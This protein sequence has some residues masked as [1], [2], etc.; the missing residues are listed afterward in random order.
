MPDL[1]IPDLA[2][3]IPHYNDVRRLHRCL[4]A[5][6]PQLTP[7]TELVVAD[8]AST[9]DL[10]PIRTA[11]PDLRIVTQPEQGA[12]AARNK[13]VTETTAP[14]LAFL[15]ADC[16]PAADWL[17]TAHRIAASQGDAVTGGRVDVFDETPAPR[18]GAEGF[19]TVFAFDQA[20]YIADK[21][22]SVT[23]NLVTTRTVFDAIGPLVPG[24]SEDLEW[25]RRA[26][27]AGFAL[28]YA[29]DLA[30]SHPTRTDW[31]ALSRKWRRLTDESWGFE[32]RNGH[33]GVGVRAAW[34]ARAI[35]HLPAS[36][37][38]HARRVLR[39]PRL[40]PA[41]KRAALTTLARLRLTRAA[42]MLRQAAQ[43]SS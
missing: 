38:V 43:R 34:A 23:A 8:N 20:S 11:W 17:A 37:P 29:P 10:S 12:A 35:I 30:V 26:T 39:D 7:R 22:F 21:G 28:H 18:S 4:T 2:V 33:H 19:E 31:T 3:I 15:D 25:C 14:H 24:L 16:L 5:L 32:G 27:A 42:W 40:T 9:D 13:G 36:I 41:E 6:M 1:P